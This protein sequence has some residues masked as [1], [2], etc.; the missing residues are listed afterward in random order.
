VLV[1]TCSAACLLDFALLQRTGEKFADLG[2]IDADR[3]AQGFDGL[4]GRRP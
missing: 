2:D 3:C 1:A 4:R